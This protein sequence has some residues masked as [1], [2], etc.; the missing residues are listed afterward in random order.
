MCGRFSCASLTFQKHLL[1]IGVTN[2][3]AYLFEPKFNIGPTDTHPVILKNRNHIVVQPAVWGIAAAWS[4]NPTQKLHNAKL[5]TA[6]DKPMFKKAFLNQRCLIPVDGF[7]EWK[8]EG[9]S[10]QPYWF[11]IENEAVFF[12]A[13]MYFVEESKLHFV[14]L[15]QES[16][17]PVASIH[18]RQPAIVESQHAQDWLTKTGNIDP[19][20]LIC[21]STVLF[22]RRVSRKVNQISFNSAECL[23]EEKSIE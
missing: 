16:Q 9:K 19:A 20:S 22:A 23:I 3:S 5:E 4:K 14:I 10:K 1:D 13:G 21:P 17:Q 2:V 11:S 15:T 12:L 6:V 18:H 7:Y 8:A